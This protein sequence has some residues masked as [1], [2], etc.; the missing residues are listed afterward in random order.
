[1][2]NALRTIHAPADEAQSGPNALYAAAV[3][4]WRERRRDEAIK[5]M[6]EAL[7]LKPDFAD[8]LCMG[9]YM[10]S[11]RGKPELSDAF[12]ST[13]PRARRLTGRRAHQFRQASVRRRPIR[14][15][16]RFLCRGDGAG[17]G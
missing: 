8:A 17:A 9:G 13:R 4:L 1:M 14:G 12:L 16:A 10:L 7:R 3:T 11:E 2:P 6:D 15:S 5:L